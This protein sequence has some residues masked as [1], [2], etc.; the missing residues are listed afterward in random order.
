MNGMKTAHRLAAFTVATALLASCGQQADPAT[1]SAP[2]PASSATAGGAGPTQT[3]VDVGGYEL[4]IACRGSGSPTVVFEAGLGGDSS[5]FSSIDDD[6]AVTTTTCGYDRAGVGMSDH[7]PSDSPASAGDLAD[8]LDRLLT[9]AGIDGPI[10]LVGHSLGGAVEQ[11]FADRH[12][13]RVTGLVFVDP[14]I[15]GTATAFGRMWEDGTSTL[16]MRRSK[17]ELEAI[18]SFGSVPTIVL[19]QA[20]KGPGDSVAPPDFRRL[21]TREHERLSARS[22]DGIH[23]IAFDSGHMIQ[24]DAP[25]L[26]L[27]AIEEVL[28]AAGADQ[29]LAPCDDRFADVGGECAP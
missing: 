21:W 8:E 3:Y 22:S 25:E 17:E 7:R 6:V 13:D 14:V 16:D 27:A 5:A 23:L 24:D 9:G 26:V 2:P 1:S 18:G 28:A 19:T 4:F 15:A 12:P 20:F 10:V 11:L 29:P